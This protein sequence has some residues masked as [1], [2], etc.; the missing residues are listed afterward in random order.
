MELRE[1]LA[2]FRKNW[3]LILVTTL[4]A[5]G[6]AAAYSLV[7]TPQYQAQTELFVSVRTG[8][9]STGDLTQGSTYVRQAVTSYVSVVTSG[10]VL[11]QV[12]DELDLDTTANALAERITASS[13][14]NTVLIDIA[15]TD[16]DP[17]QAAL[18]ANTLSSV[19]SDVV[20]NDLE[21][22]SEGQAARVQLQTIQPAQV[23]SAPVSPKVARNLALGFLLGLFLGIGIAVLREVLDTRVRSKADIAAITDLP[24][25]G[26][27]GNDPK[28][29]QRPLIALE[30]PRNPLV[31]SYRTLRTNLQYINVDNNGKK[32]IVITSA[33]PSEGKSTTAANLAIV[34]AD[35]GSRILIID[36][37]LRKPKISKLL[38]I[39][40]GNG[41]SDLLIGR[42]NLEDALQ[43]WGR[44]QIF[45]LPAGRIPP[46]PSELLQSTA[47]A[48]LLEKLAGHFDFIII[49][50]TPVLAVTDAAI[51]SNLTGGAIV[52]SAAGKTRKEEL[53][54]AL[55]SLKA[56]GGKVI[57]I[58]PTMVPTKGP[59]SYGYGAY[60]YQRYGADETTPM[61]QV[62]HTGKTS[63]H[64]ENSQRI[65]GGI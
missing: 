51:L 57:G 11:D 58:L 41:L 36:A 2:I 35:T 16:P 5:T 60:S 18:I 26:T 61:P 32:S 47:M 3:I 17:D 28:A 22:P 8:E 29:D 33:G 10:V 6:A 12:I 59:D 65:L 45:V 20:S 31:E 49:D 48:R 1:Y 63:G 43:R 13:P 64:A 23:P 19:F 15:V 42:I 38:G 55:E 21:N 14:T 50:T 30:S 4:L 56:V 34:M 9:A 37:D 40:G 44:Q 24:I 39:E 53:A 62:P 54:N 25:I 52:V 27:V 7:A 46:N